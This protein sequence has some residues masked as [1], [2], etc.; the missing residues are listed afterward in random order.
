MGQVKGH[1]GQGQPE[2]PDIGWWAYIN[3]K[4]HF[5]KFNLGCVT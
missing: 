2:A 1:V 4:L 5:L 3:V